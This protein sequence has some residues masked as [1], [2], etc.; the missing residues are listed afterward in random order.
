MRGVPDDFNGEDQMVQT[1]KMKPNITW[2]AHL[3]GDLEGIGIKDMDL[4]KLSAGLSLGVSVNNYLGP[5]LELG[6]KGGVSFQ[7]AEKVK[8]EKGSATDSFALKIG[9]GVNATVNSGMA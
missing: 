2:G 3:T 7:V 1:Q 5:A 8:S 9:G 4:I 6:V